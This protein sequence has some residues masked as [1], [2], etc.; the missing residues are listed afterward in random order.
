MKKISEKQLNTLIL[1]IK[2]NADGSLLDINQLMDRLPHSPTKEA[3]QFTIRQ[4]IEMGLIEKRDPETR[5]GSKRIVYSGT[6]K[7]YLTVKSLK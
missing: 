2:C 7:G 4:L 6:M 3:L 5:R 1:I